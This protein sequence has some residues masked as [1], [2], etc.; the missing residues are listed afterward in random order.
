MIEMMEKSEVNSDVPFMEQTKAKETIN[1]A[2]ETFSDLS[3]Q[4]FGFGPES[5]YFP[6]WRLW[7]SIC[8]I[9]FHKGDFTAYLTSERDKS[10]DDSGGIHCASVVLIL[11]SESWMCDRDDPPPWE[12]TAG[13]MAGRK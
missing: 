7:L 13:I 5:G 2:N 6:G 9:L 3:K 10:G 11:F 1:K 8:H 12:Y 4:F